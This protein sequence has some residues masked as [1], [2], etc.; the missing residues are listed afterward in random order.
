MLSKDLM[1]L[2]DGQPNITV[3]DEKLSLHDAVNKA[4]LEGRAVR[5]LGSKA[6]GTAAE[7]S[8]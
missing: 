3:N 4:L 8:P 2:I 1:T 7:E 6:S 5:L